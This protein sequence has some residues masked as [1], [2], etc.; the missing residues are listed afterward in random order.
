[1]KTLLAALLVLG[2]CSL[3]PAP[4]ADSPSR[5]LRSVGEIEVSIM[6]EILMFRLGGT[7]QPLTLEDWRIDRIRDKVEES[8]PVGD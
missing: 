7:G 8:V 1:M 4:R 6:A 2:L 5:A 3:A